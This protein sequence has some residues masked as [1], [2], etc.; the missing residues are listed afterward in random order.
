[1]N[2]RVGFWRFRLELIEKTWGAGELPGDGLGLADGEG[3]ED[4]EGL[5]EGLEDGE[6]VGEGS[7][8]GQPELMQT[9]IPPL[10]AHGGDAVLTTAAS[11]WKGSKLER[12]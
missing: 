8:L 6:G 9:C 4:G 2:V 12:K 11:A 7:G 5:G 10:A 3:L 1:M